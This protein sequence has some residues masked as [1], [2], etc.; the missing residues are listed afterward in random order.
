M[1][2]DERP[3]SLRLAVRLLWTL[4]VLGAATVVLIVMRED[5]LIRTWAEGNA[6][7][8]ETLQSQG[9]D[10]V[11]DGSVAPPQFVPVAIT[12]YV[13][14]A[15]LVWVLT[16]FLRNGFEWA[17]SGITV[18]LVF[19]AIASIGGMRVGQPALFDVGTMVCL[20]L[21][22]ATLAPMWH[23]ATTAYIHAD[24]DAVAAA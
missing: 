4:M 24:P 11:K 23:P 18:L 17:R 1:S 21:A 12:L 19:T 14:L 5:D 22:A 15:S 8:R 3:M 2:V 16:I 7:T 13:V 6:A 9:L 10:A 20:A